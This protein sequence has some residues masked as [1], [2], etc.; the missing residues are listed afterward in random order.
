[1]DEAPHSGAPRS[2][3]QRRSGLCLVRSGRLLHWAVRPI[4]KVDNAIDAV[5]MPG[6]VGL[7]ADVA[8]RPQLNPREGRRRA[9]GSAEHDMTAIGKT[10]AQRPP[11]K[12]ACAGHEDASQA[13]ATRWRKPSTGKCINEA[14]G[15]TST[16]LPSGDFR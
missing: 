11:D 2:T 13:S 7:R 3:R 14:T 10:A 15:R 4:G 8:D 16:C 12:A 1:M 9:A 5:E 6:P